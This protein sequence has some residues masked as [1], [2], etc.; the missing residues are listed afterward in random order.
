MR[1]RARFVGTRKFER[2]EAAGR[3]MVPAVGTRIEGAVPIRNSD[4]LNTANTA[5][6]SHAGGLYAL[7]EGG[8]AYEVDPDTLQSLGPK[9]WR[10]DLQSMPFSAHPL[11]E[12]DGSC[13]NFGLLGSTLVLWHLDPGGSV[14]DV[15]TL[16]MPFPGYMH[17]FSMTERYLVFV[18]QPYVAHRG[19]SGQP[20][21]K[22]LQWEPKRG[23]RV[24]VVDK[25]DMDRRRWYGL[26]AGAAYHYGAARQHGREIL[27]SACWKQDGEQALS[28]FRAEMRGVSHPVDLGSSLQVIRLGLDSGEAG[29]DAVVVGG[30]DFPTWDERADDGCMFVLTGNDT[31]ESGYF[32]AVSRIDPQ[33]GIVDH[34]H[35]G[36][37]CM[38]EEHRFVPAADDHLPGQGWLVGTVLDYRRGRTGLSILQADNL[39]AGPVAQAWLPHTVPLGFHGWFEPAHG[40]HR[41]A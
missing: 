37:G 33:H 19:E 32:D 1:H 35:Y 34:Y 16:A 36:E 10:E 9:A 14:R 21:F 31:S 20:Y 26:P 29:M 2:E 15:R 7:W 12:S 18:L 38:V 3:F 25:S 28:P 40:Q 23:C 30:L 6:F 4:D 22:T 27:L 5:V 41:G 39:R 17:A 8:S 13:R 11:R 24:L